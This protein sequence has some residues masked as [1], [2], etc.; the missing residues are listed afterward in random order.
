MNIYTTYTQKVCG[1]PFKLVD[2]A[3]SAKPVADRCVTSSTQPCN[4][5]KAC[6]LH[7]QKLSVECGTVMGC[8]VSNKSVHQI[9]ALLKLPRS[10]VSAVIV[11]WKC[12]EATTAKPRPGRPHKFT[13]QDCQVL[14]C[15]KII[16]PLLQHSLSSSKLPRC[17]VS[18]RTVRRERH[19]MGFHGRAAAHKPKITMCYAKRMLEWCEARRDWTLKQR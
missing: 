17:N 10:T 7:R 2:L 5:G 16:W 12:L 4:L 18:T 19:E 1:H 9:S 6:N 13:E 8:H 11:K 14:K 3:I 15:I